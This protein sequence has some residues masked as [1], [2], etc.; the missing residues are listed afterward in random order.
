MAAFTEGLCPAIQQSLLNVPNARQYGRTPTGVIDALNSASNNANVT[1]DISPLKD[2]RGKKRQVQVVAYKRATPADAS[3]S[4]QN[5]CDATAEDAP[6]EEIV[7]I[8]E[9]VGI[10]WMVDESNMRLICDNPQ[11]FVNGVLRMK[12]DAVTQKYEQ[13]ALAKLVPLIGGYGST[14]RGVTSV[15]ITNAG[16]SYET[17]PTVVFTGG[18]GS[19]AAATATVDGSGVVTAITMTNFGTG[20]TSAPTVSFTGGGGADAAGTAVIGVTNSNT[21]PTTFNV[22]NADGSLNAYE[23][24]QME[25]ALQEAGFVNA[26]LVVGQN[27]Q[28]MDAA[29]RLMGIACCNDAGYD[30]S[31]LA[32]L[33]FYKSRAIT[34]GLGNANNVLAFDPGAVKL[35]TFNEN[36][37]W[38]G[39]EDPKAL[40]TVITDPV[41]NIDWDFE[42]VW[43]QCD[44]AWQFSLNLQFTAFAMPKADLYKTTDFLYGTN[45]ALVFRAGKA[46]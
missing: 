10:S 43:S 22:L 11:D 16:S 25:M 40:R 23:W 37:D 17:A 19:G 9:A 12:L 34:A 30:A 5:V 31:Q 2:V 8:D 14:Y 42:A 41:K 36:V 45:G 32:M 29:T 39:N 26:P 27:A 38:F 21:L 3:D 18:G 24:A 6:Y 7:E 33:D 20:Y 46:S 35:I 28:Y 13:V 1:F 15:T 4:L 44:K